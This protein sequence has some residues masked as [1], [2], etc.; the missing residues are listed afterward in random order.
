M[1]VKKTNSV[2]LFSTTV[3]MHSCSVSRVSSNKSWITILP[4]SKPPGAGISA[5]P[6]QDTA[7]NRLPCPRHTGH[8]G[9]CR[10]ST[11]A[12]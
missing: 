4:G 8:S 9:H 2:Q 10:D 12:S 5:L 7:Y 11:G 1:F 3:S 6:G